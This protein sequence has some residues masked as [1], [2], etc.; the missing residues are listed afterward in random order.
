MIPTQPEP[1]ILK[2][3]P[4][5]DLTNSG[6]GGLTGLTD[7]LDGPMMSPMSSQLFS[8]STGAALPHGLPGSNDP[9]GD[10]LMGWGLGPLGAWNPDL[11]GAESSLSSES[12]AGLADLIAKGLLRA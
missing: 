4:N 1:C 11:D 10:G 3:E 5:L 7:L 12:L 2:P 6:G 9:V 8:P